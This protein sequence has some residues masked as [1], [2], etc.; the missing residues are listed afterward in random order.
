VDKKKGEE[1]GGWWA[2]ILFSV[3]RGAALLLS[4]FCEKVFFFCPDRDP[5]RF[6]LSCEAGCGFSSFYG[7]FSESF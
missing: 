1:A 2:M 4:F 5:D 6:F 3:T 7:T